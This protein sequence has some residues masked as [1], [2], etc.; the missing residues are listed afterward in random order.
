MQRILILEPDDALRADIARALD[1]FGHQPVA[2]RNLCE[3]GVQGLIE[4]CAG[5]VVDLADAS[6]LEVIVRLHK[7]FPE[8]V[9]LATGT[10]PSVE[11][12]VGAMKR[13]AC[14]FLRKPFS[15]NDLE[16]ALDNALRALAPQRGEDA[17]PEI[18][19][20]D[21]GMRRLFQQARAAACTEATVLIQGESGVGKELLARW[22]HAKSSR[23]N[24]PFV[25]VNCAALPETLADS[26][27]FGHE[28]GAFT[29]ALDARAGQVRA[30]QGGSL[31]LDEVNE[32]SLG[33]QPKLLRVLQEREVSPVGAVAPVPVDVRVLAITQRDLEEEVARGHFREDLYYRLDVIA[34]RVP[35]LRDR[36]GDIPLLAEAFAQKFARASGLEPPRLDDEAM[37]RLL[38]HPFRGNV[39][40]LENLMRR[41]VVL[42]PG[43]RLEAARL[44]APRA[45]EEVSALAMGQLGG[46]LNLRDMERRLI[47]HS[48]NVMGGN[49]TAASKALGISVR[50]LRNKIRQYELA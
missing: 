7:D 16:R 11:L 27:L 22:L 31:L 36:P 8:L 29:G 2:R 17:S 6:G 28:K 46:S 40:E 49:R 38:R 37:E 47:V 50:T 9:I 14:D 21:A 30:A 32:L 18:L 48:L 35:A 26:E 45:P 23:C 33:I 5:A 20:E 1:S 4:G 15:V 44:L 24:A 41:A 25:S 39:R 43:R 13:G 12:A 42:Y 19:T 10:L 34:L 3:A